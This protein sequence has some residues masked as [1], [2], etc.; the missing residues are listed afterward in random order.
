MLGGLPNTKGSVRRGDQLRVRPI[1]TDSVL[2]ALGALPQFVDQLVGAV[3]VEILQQT[4]VTE[5]SVDTII[6]N[7]AGK[8]ELVTVVNEVLERQGGDAGVLGDAGVRLAVV[9]VGDKLANVGALCGVNA[10]V[11]IFLRRTRRMGGWSIFWPP[12]RHGLP[13]GYAGAAVGL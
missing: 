1:H 11:S 12:V 10:E 3:L 5:S 7:L 2:Q 9:D 6:V 8:V 4:D 13:T